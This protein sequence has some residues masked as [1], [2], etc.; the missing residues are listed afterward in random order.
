MPP[1]SHISPEELRAKLV[2]VWNKVKDHKFVE[3]FVC[4]T[5]NHDVCRNGYPFMHPVKVCW[6][7]RSFVSVSVVQ[8]SDAPKYDK[9]I[10]HPMDFTTS[11][12]IAVV[13]LFLCSPDPFCSQLIHRLACM[14]ISNLVCTAVLCAFSFLARSF[15][16]CHDLQCQEIRYLCCEHGV[17][18]RISVI[19]VAQMASSLD[20]HAVEVLQEA[21]P[22]IASSFQMAAPAPAPKACVSRCSCCV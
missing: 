14:N 11:G 3:L 4:L 8:L 6:A 1:L 20:Q 19:H 22:E 7:F 10:K 2:D 13:E 21:F 9:Y 18:V 17:L 15:R 12:V 5:L 16:E